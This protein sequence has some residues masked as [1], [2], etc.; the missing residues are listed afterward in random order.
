MKILH[1]G[2]VQSDVYIYVNIYIY[3]IYFSDPVIPKKSY[4]E[5]LGNQNKFCCLIKK[6]TG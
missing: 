2:V 4:N 5:F 6:V 3:I 1:F